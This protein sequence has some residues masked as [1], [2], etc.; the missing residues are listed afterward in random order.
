ML[1]LV[2]RDN[3]WLHELVYHQDELLRRIRKAAPEAEV[4]RLRTRVGQVPRWRPPEPPPPDPE[5]H[6]LANE[7][8]AETQDAL[9]SIE[10]SALQQ[11]IANARMAL[12][13]RVMRSR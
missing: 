3:Q 1:T 5:L 6:T 9:A 2:V 10:D 8:S 13:D 4:T 7:P 12:T 11:T